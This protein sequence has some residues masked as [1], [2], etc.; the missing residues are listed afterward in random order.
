MSGW[1]WAWLIWGLG[2]IAIEGAALRN[3]TTGDTLSEHVWKLF[4][5]AR[6]QRADR[7]TQVRRVALLGFMA[8]LAVHFMTGGW[9]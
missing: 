9:L 2:F 4:H 3:K 7:T 5:T 1:T 6:G 8:W